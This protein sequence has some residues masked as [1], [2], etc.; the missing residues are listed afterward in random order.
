MIESDSL[1]HEL[2]G[3]EQAAQKTLG[4][5]FGIDIIPSE[6]R[7]TQSFLVVVLLEYEKVIRQPVKIWYLNAHMLQEERPRKLARQGVS[8]NCLVCD[9]ITDVF[10]N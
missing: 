2:Q 8:Q 5:P 4:L 6:K 3:V 10:V 1:D 9:C 7:K